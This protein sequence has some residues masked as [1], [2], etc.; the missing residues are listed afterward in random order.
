MHL[1]AQQMHHHRIILRAA[2]ANEA[3]FVTSGTS[4]SEGIS[5]AVYE[6]KLG[7]IDSLMSEIQYTF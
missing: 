3:R 6:N 4:V 2:A 7:I 5:Q 1:I